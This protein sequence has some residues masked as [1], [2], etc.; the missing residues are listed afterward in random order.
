MRKSRW[1]INVDQRLFLYIRAMV[2]VD[3]KL[4]LMADINAFWQLAIIFAHSDTTKRIDI[5]ILLV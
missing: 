3:H 2:S 4:F 5:V 1:S